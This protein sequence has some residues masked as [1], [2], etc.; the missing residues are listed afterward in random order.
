MSFA[1]ICLLG[2]QELSVFLKKHCRGYATE[3]EVCRIR[4]K[5]TKSRQCPYEKSNV[6]F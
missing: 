6:G 4:A 5:D 2:G 3:G 1:V